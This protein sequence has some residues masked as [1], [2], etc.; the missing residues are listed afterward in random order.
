M[1]SQVLRQASRSVA[2][3]ACCVWWAGGTRVE[4]D[5]LYTSLR[6]AD[7]TTLR[8]E[9]AAPYAKRDLGVQRCPAPAGWR[10]FLVSSDA[11][12]WIDLTGPGVAWSAE[13][14][15]VYDAPIG[16]FPSVGVPATLEWR[17]DGRGR[18]IAL[19]FRVTAQ[20]REK[21]QARRSMLYVVR[22]QAANACVIGRLATNLAAR[23]LADSSQQ[24]R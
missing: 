4:A 20:D 14:P 16:N 1:T 9:A 5:S 24:C 13:R 8:G 17:R 23:R 3:A 11:N 6:E 7:C 2:V 21:L 18:L 19:I 22:L 12:T 15:I 10:V